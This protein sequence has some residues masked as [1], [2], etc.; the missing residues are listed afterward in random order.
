MSATRGIVESAKAEAARR[1]RRAGSA[2]SWAAGTPARLARR[3]RRAASVRAASASG[4]AIRPRASSR[5][6][7]RSWS[8]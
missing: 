6:I 3:S 2:M 4:A 8:S 5:S 7:S 1:W